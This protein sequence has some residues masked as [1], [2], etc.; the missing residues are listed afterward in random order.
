MNSVFLKVQNLQGLSSQGSSLTPKVSFELSAG[1]V[2]L[3]T[4][5]NGS[6]KSTLLKALLKRHSPVSGNLEW[7]FGFDQIEYL[8]QLGNLAFHIPFNLR[9]LL[10]NDV[11]SPLLQGL[12]LN[13]QWNT[14]S[15]GERQRV[16][17]AAALAKNPL[18]LILDEPFNHVD[19]AT[20]VLLEKT[21]KEFIQSHPDRAMILVSHRPLD[22]SWNGIRTLEL[23]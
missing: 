21:L 1:D 14:A 11:S 19:Q 22:L 4:G 16:L 12:D 17:L 7:K 9:D 10:E 2:L 13:K 8:P 18:V 20:A 3:L 15:G 6:G 5:E 23:S